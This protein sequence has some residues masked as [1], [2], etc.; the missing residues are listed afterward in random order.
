SNFSLEEFQQPEFEGYGPKTSKS[1]SEDTSK[2]VRESPDAP[3]CRK[4]ISHKGRKTKPRTT[5]LSAEWKCVK[6]RSKIKAKES[7]KLDSQP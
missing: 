3:V 4:R 6:R 2:K 7:I 1:V 5:K